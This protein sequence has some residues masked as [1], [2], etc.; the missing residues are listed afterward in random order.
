[1][2]EELEKTIGYTF[3]NKELLY[4]ALTHSSFANEARDRRRGSNER[5]EFLGSEVILHARLDAIGETMIVKLT[6][7]EATGL[8]AGTPV[9]LTLA[10]EQAM[11]FA[12]D[13]RR[14]RTSPLTVDATREKAHG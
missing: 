5:M 2:T 12:E 8:A 9:A 3:K 1:M 10:P 14:L 6:P 4:N 7:A 11:V 13:G